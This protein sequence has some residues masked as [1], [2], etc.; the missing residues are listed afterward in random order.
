MAIRDKNV[1]DNNSYNQFAQQIV[2]LG[3]NAVNASVALA[4]GSLGSAKMPWAGKILSAQ[5]NYST[6]SG[7][8]DLALAKN[9]TA[10]SNVTTSGTN[11]LT[12]TASTFASGDTLG[13]ICT[14]AA[15]EY[16]IGSCTVI[17]RPYLGAAERYAASLGD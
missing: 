16:A 10:I 1:D 12:L 11:A 17:V 9:G 7:S 5:I 2:I 3:F 8:V 15:N 13:L 6:S 14:T 4:S